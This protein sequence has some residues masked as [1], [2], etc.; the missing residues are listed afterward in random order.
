VRL[1]RPDRVVVLSSLDDIL[2]SI[3]ARQRRSEGPLNNAEV[4]QEREDALQQQLKREERK[5]VRLQELKQEQR[6][7]VIMG[8]ARDLERNRRLLKKGFGES[9]AGQANAGQ[10]NVYDYFAVKIQSLARKFLR[11]RWYLAYWR[12]RVPSC[13]RIQAHVRGMQCRVQQAESRAMIVATVSIQA[14]ARGFHV[15]RREMR[16]LEESAAGRTVEVIQRTWRGVRGRQ[17]VREKRLFD[18]SVRTAVEAV[19]EQKVSAI[20]V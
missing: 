10:E 5:D 3:A 13:I 2:T 19:T 14:A 12:D 7:N 11:R 17:R 16:R 20:D 15:R 1:V 4:L 8:R 18:E 6:K 9:V